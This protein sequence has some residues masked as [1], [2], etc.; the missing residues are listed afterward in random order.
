MLL[1]NFVKDRQK[2]K[3]KNGGK[4]LYQVQSVLMG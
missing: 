1:E 2:N 3:S 4:A